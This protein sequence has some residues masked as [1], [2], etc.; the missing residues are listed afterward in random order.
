MRHHATVTTISWIPS[1]AVGG[2][3]KAMFGTGFVHYDDPPP[4]VIDDLQEM[5]GADRFRFA[6]HLGA[7]IEVDDAGRIV[8]AEYEGG[9]VM[10]A[11]TVAVGGARATFA[12][13]SL[14]DLRPPVEI[15]D[16]SARFVQTVGGHTALPA[17]R[18]VNKAPFVQFEA[19]TVWTTLALTVHADGSSEHEL[20][21]ASQFPRH[22]VYGD[23]KR[24]IAKAGLAD[25][26][27]WWRHSF[28]RHTPWGDQDSA[29]LVT[30]VETALERQ[31]AATVMRGDQKVKTRTI[32]AGSL[33][34]EQGAEG[35]EV[36]LLLNGV[37]S[38]EV[39]GEPIA[40]VGPGAILGE[41][42]LLEGGRRTATLRA[43]SK[44]KVAVAR[45]EPVDHGVLAEISHGHRREMQG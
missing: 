32:K 29:A 9:C 40:Q 43:A 16:G 31:V 5:C 11:T 36:F 26:K 2:L 44:V 4:D 6:N 39:D 7:W 42:A 3:N 34:T 24:L 22:W 19:P 37:L 23:D 35:D 45:T 38:V 14:P 15:V 10:G 12:A 21:G 30:E 25:F 18:R 1:E 41:R 27:E 13:V 20:I 17:P 28:G 8:R 33:L